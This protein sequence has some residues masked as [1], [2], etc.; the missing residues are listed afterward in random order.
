M[1]DPESEAGTTKVVSKEIEH[2]DYQAENDYMELYTTKLLTFTN[3]AKEAGYE[4]FFLTAGVSAEEAKDF[5]DDTG[6]EAKVF[7]GDDILLKTIIRSNP[8]VLI[9]DDATIRSKY[10]IRKLPGFEEI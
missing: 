4:I 9:M 5:I 8:G 6:I 2:V 10:H 3:K 1:I 7:T